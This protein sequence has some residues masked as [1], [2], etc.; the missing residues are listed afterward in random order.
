M[1]CLISNEVGQLFTLFVAI[2]VQ[3][4]KKHIAQSLRRRD[5]V[6]LIGCVK[7]RIVVSQT[8]VLFLTDLTCGKSGGLLL[9]CGKHLTQLFGIQDK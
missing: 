4:T 8:V 5:L 1:S 7:L 2:V 6:A 9:P 3:C